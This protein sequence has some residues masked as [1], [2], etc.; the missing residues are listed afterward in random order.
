MS[1][2]PGSPQNHYHHQ[3][4][5]PAASTNAVP[6]IQTLKDQKRSLSYNT[7]DPSP[8]A[9]PEDQITTSPTGKKVD[10]A[11]YT[12]MMKA[13]L[14]GFLNSSEAKAEVPK[15]KL[16]N[17]L[18]DTER[19]SRQARRASLSEGAHGH[20]HSLGRGTRSLLDPMESIRRS[21][22]HYNGIL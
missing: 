9:S 5:Y 12:K 8:I 19:N 7:K 14:T 1:S 16:Q 2:H 13:S 18:M 22:Q 21:E 20:G 15:R 6:T 10:D 4:Q 3:Y 17:M 11:S